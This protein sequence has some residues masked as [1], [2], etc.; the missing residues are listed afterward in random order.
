MYRVEGDGMWRSA[1][2]FVLAALSLLEPSLCAKKYNITIG[3]LPCLTGE[4][5]DRQGLTIS[6]ALSIALE[7]VGVLQCIF[8]FSISV[9]KP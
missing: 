4:L 7:E 2:V 1:R 3:Y 9:Q 6:G 5:R 8:K